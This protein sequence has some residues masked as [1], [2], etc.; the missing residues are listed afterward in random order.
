MW[1]VRS[2]ADVPAQNMTVVLNMEND[3]KPFSEKR[4][5]A[6]PKEAF[7]ELKIPSQE[8]S[9]CE[10]W[11]YRKNDIEFYFGRDRILVLNR[12]IISNHK[13]G[14]KECRSQDTQL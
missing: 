5:S 14:E 3:H 12:T 8:K 6:I 7:I 13:E 9:K 11:Y 2:G 10:S 1:L 4:Q